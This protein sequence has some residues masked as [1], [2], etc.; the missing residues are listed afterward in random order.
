MAADWGTLHDIKVDNMMDQFERNKNI[1]RS[2]EKKALGLLAVVSGDG[3]EDIMK[4]MHAEVLSGGQTMNPS[5]QEIMQALDALYADNYIIL[6]NNKNIILAAKQAQKILG[7]KLQ[8]VPTANPA[9]GAA[10]AMQ[11]DPNND[12]AS[13]VER[14]CKELEHIRAAGITQAVRDSSVDGVKIAKDDYMGLI[15]GE[16][17]ITAAELSDVL[18]DVLE[19]LVSMQP[20]AE[21]ITLYYGADLDETQANELLAQAQAKHTNIDLELQYGGQSLYPFFISIE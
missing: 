17:V 15:S 20:D 16:R 10:V 1:A 12:V 7:E 4:N 6:P 9:E 18:A 13:N 21:L 2:N 14:M 8:I 5:V 11:Y 3:W 19:K